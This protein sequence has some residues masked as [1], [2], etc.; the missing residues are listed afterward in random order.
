MLFFE[1]A[2]PQHSEAELPGQAVRPR[3]LSKFDK[4]AY[5]LQMRLDTFEEAEPDA[6]VWCKRKKR[7]VCLRSGSVKVRAKLLWGKKKTQ[8][9]KKRCSCSKEGLGD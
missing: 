7:S 5:L 3:K 6:E 1:G 4:S 8:E 9:K 2:E